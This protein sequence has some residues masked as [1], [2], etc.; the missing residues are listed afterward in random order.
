MKH[1]VEVQVDDQRARQLDTVETPPSMFK[2]H[3]K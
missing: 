2:N 3:Q 1:S